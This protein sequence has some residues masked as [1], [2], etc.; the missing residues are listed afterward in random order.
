MQ[1]HRFF[2]PIRMAFPTLLLHLDERE[3]VSRIGPLLDFARD[4]G[5]K[6]LT[7]VA[8][9]GVTPP[10]HGVPAGPFLMLLREREI[11]EAFADMEA[12][13]TARAYCFSLEWRS[14]VTADP[15][16]FVL[17]QSARADLMIASRPAQKTGRLGD[18]DLGRLLVGAGRP[19]LIPAD[20]SRAI[21]RRRIAIGFKPTREGRLAVTASLPLLKDAEHVAIIGLGQESR[22]DDLADVVAQLGGHGI[23]AEELALPDQPATGEALVKAALSIGADILVC[24]AYGHGRAQEFLF[25]GITRDLIAACPLPCLMIH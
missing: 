7:V 4:L 20:P 22:T 2:W 10:G 19:V 5:V 18:L 17:D 3:D 15:T 14:D 25:G 1:A 24:G 12:E 11:R 13:L 23:L 9:G 6:D 8:A 16:R 21:D